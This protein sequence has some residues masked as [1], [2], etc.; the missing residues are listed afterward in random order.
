M[1]SHVSS[2][3]N[4]TLTS[5]AIYSV[6]QYSIRRIGDKGKVRKWAY[7]ILSPRLRADH[8]E[9]RCCGRSVAAPGPHARSKHGRK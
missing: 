9:A 7:R 2:R 5:P 8:W 3:G 1:L 6:L 4:Y